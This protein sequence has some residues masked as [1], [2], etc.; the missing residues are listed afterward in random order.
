MS[1]V[2]VL[3]SFA[4]QI[5]VQAY[6]LRLIYDTHVD[7]SYDPSYEVLGIVSTTNQLAAWLEE[8]IAERSDRLPGDYDPSEYDLFL[9]PGVSVQPV[10][11]SHRD[12]PLDD[13]EE[14]RER[15]GASV[16]LFAEA[17]VICVLDKSLPLANARAANQVLDNVRLRYIDNTN[18]N[19][20]RAS[21]ATDIFVVRQVIDPAEI[22]TIDA[23]TDEL[24]LGYEER[25]TH[26]VQ[27]GDS[28]WSMAMS[29]VSERNVSLEEAMQQLEETNPHIVTAG[30]MPGDVIFLPTENIPLIGVS[31]TETIEVE[32]D[33]PYEVITRFSD[34]Y[35]VNDRF[36]EKP[37][38]PGKKVSEYIVTNHNGVEQGK[39]KRKEI[40]IYDPEPEYV[41]RG[42]LIPND[43]GTG[44]FN[45]PTW[46]TI[47]DRF[48]WR[49]LGYHYGV[50]ISSGYGSYILASDSGI[51]T[52][53]GWDSGGLGLSVTIDHRNGTMTRYGHLSDIWVSVNDGIRQGS[54]IGLEGNTGFS[55]GAH[56]HFELFLY[57][58]RVDPLQWL[59][60]SIE[61]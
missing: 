7:G 57:G 1:L 39:V 11:H 26:L 34:E 16:Q 6:E 21:F 30:L 15:L 53:A 25:Q 38:V 58:V 28:L 37:G 4:V 42:T 20:M 27:V 59:G 12:D 24:L 33:I 45:W 8:I 3:I 40:I 47:T 32:E 54:V 22:I 36:V 56:L 49:S 17:S 44:T 46:G 23:A 2:L 48:G 61:D 50:D 19:T 18:A 60:R 9:Y 13:L 14:V 10:W 51:V 43:R 29:M 31:V 35:Y 55:F 5:P 41:L 52:Q